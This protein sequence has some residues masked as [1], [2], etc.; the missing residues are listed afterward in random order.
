MKNDSTTG[1]KVLTIKILFKMVTFPLEYGTMASSEFDS[2]IR[3]S[4][5]GHAGSL[6][7][8]RELRLKSLVCRRDSL[9]V[10]AIDCSDCWIVSSPQ[11]LSS[12][13]TLR[14]DYWSS[15]KAVSVSA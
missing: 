7:A 15:E 13:L 10:S 14:E 8:K 11:I 4:S 1:S 3:N 12:A 9:N 6:L 5:M 2:E